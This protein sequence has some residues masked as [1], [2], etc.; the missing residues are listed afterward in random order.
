MDFF[1]TY[2]G[3]LLKINYIAGIFTVVVGIIVIKI[4]G[5]V[6]K[7]GLRAAKMNKSISEVVSSLAG[8]AMWFALGIFVISALGFTRAAQIISLL[9]GAFAL[10]AGLGAQHFV[11]NVIGGFSL[12]TDEDFELGYKVKIGEVTGIV[13]KMDHRKVRLV[14]ENGKTHVFPNKYVEEN[15]WMVLNRDEE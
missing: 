12:A 2:L 15:Q 13:H 4:T 11:N 14:D 7:G 1:S 6:I 5:A 9:G 10:A 8:A 3:F